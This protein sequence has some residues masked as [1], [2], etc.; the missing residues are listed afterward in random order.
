LAVRFLGDGAEQDEILVQEILE[1]GI[2]VELLTQQFTAASGVGVKIDK[3][4]L[5]IAFGL[6]RRFVQRSF[7]PALGGSHRGEHKQ[8][9]QDE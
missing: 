2:F 5:V 7:E 8:E 1:F 3:D 9:R 6:G 4:Q